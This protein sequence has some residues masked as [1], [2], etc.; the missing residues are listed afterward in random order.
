MLDAT[1]SPPRFA[2]TARVISLGCKVNQAEATRWEVA[3]GRVG[4]ELRDGGD[5]CD[6]VVVNTCSVTMDADKSAR[7]IIRQAARANPGAFV[8]VTGCYAATDATAVGALEGVDLVVP[9]EDKEALLEG[10]A[11]AGVVPL[12]PTEGWIHPSERPGWVTTAPLLG[13]RARAFVK[14]QDGCNSHCTYCIVP[15]ARGPQRSRSIDAIVDEMILLESLGYSEV[16]LTGVQIGAY[17]RDWDRSIR[18]IRA[19]GPTLTRL[20]EQVLSRTRIQRVRI[21]S[22]Q[23]QDWPPGFIELWSDP[24]MCRHLHLPMQSGCDRTLK[25]MVRRY[26]AAD[27]AKLA[28]RL[29]AEIP[30]VAITADVMVAFPGETEADHQESMVFMREMALADAHVFRYSPRLGTAAIRLSGDVPPE[31]ARRRSQEAHAIVAGCRAEF[32]SR[33]VG[34]TMSV[35]FEEPV[36]GEDEMWS[37]LTDNYLRIRARGDGLEGMIRDV[38]L[39]AIDGEFVRGELACKTASSAA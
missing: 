30:D 32:Q 13:R 5:R 28:D 21:S 22:I 39:D 12:I 35:L 25:R 7:R 10:L 36:V 17:G 11:G 26:R 3:L 15:R 34:R 20:V 9:N 6:L 8:A 27:F 2:R 1:V 31:A 4:V 33:F 38:H 19:S 24:R 37:G 29:R 18:R 23:P 14:V 16:V